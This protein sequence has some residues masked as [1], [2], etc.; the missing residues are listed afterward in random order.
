MT[1]SLACRYLASL[2]P[3]PSAFAALS[4]EG[5]QLAGDGALAVRAAELLRRSAPG[6]SLVRDGELV[7]AR[8]AAGGALAA[9]VRGAA[10]PGLLEQDLRRAAA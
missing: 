7:V 5:V 6:L 4:P 8:G 1:A 9:E 10:L 2:W 3:A